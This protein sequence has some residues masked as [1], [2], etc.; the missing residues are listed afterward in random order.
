MQNKDLFK[1]DDS[2]N[3]YPIGALHPTRDCPCKVIKCT[4]SLV[5]A[6]DSAGNIRV[7]NW[8]DWRIENANKNTLL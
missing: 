7:F 8:Q 2:I 4:N 6:K 1:K 3:A 5:E